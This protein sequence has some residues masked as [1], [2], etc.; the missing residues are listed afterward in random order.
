MCL[1]SLFLSSVSMST[2]PRPIF[3]PISPAKGMEVLNITGVLVSAA[4]NFSCSFTL[5]L[6]PA[7]IWAFC[8]H[9]AW[10]SCKAGVKDRWTEV[11]LWGVSS[12]LADVLCRV[13]FSGLAGIALKGVVDNCLPG[14]RLAA[15]L[16]VFVP[17]MMPRG[18]VCSAKT[19]SSLEWLCIWWE[20]LWFL[21]ATSSS[22]W[23][24]PS[25]SV[26]SLCWR[27]KRDRR[28]DSARFGVSQCPRE[29]ESS[30]SWN[31][32]S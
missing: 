27:Y 12:G 32:P 4:V 14:A 1:R 26:D 23:E 25:L 6:W 5:G 22:D 24:P 20:C 29:A 2:F 10:T 3:L 15:V 30:S 13:T 31:E 19:S 16:S 18:V 8:W 9:M 28:F 11:L 17:E 21:S 7:N